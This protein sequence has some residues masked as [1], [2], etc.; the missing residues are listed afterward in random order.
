[1]AKQQYVVKRFLLE[2]PAHLH[3]VFDH[4]RAAGLPQIR[5]QWQRCLDSQSTKRKSCFPTETDH[6]NL[7]HLRALSLPRTSALTKSQAREE[8]ADKVGTMTDIHNELFVDITVH[9]MTTRIA[10]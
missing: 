6:L 7:F 1:M 9:I 2:G 10:I 8:D 3:R 5:P 4:I